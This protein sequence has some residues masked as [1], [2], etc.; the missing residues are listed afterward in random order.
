MKFII[1]RVVKRK[2]SFVKETCKLSKHMTTGG[3]YT[4]VAVNFQRWEHCITIQHYIL[5]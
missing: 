3:I 2:I 5:M 1:L 4:D